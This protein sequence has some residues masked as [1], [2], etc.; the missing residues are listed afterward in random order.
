MFLIFNPHTTPTATPT[1]TAGTTNLLQDWKLSKMFQGWS[2]IWATEPSPLSPWDHP[3]SFSISSHCVSSVPSHWNTSAT[4]PGTSAA[5]GQAI[6]QQVSSRMG[7]CSVCL[8]A[9]PSSWDKQ[10]SGLC[11]KLHVLPHFK[12]KH[13][14]TIHGTDKNCIWVRPGQRFAHKSQ[15]GALNLGNASVLFEHSCCQWGWGHCWNLS[16]LQS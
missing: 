14:S 5:A 15:P 10:L 8:W 7:C 9:H 16:K 12:H 4:V 3:G 11:L 6:P 13:A 2:C 1:R